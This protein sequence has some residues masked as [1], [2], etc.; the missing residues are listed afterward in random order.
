MAEEPDNLLLRLMRELR[1]G[2][3]ETNDRLGKIEQR[4]DDFQETTVTALGLAG[5]SNIRHDSIAAEIASIKKRLAKLEEK[6]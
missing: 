4:L 5:H 1:D 6:A 3:L 2:Q